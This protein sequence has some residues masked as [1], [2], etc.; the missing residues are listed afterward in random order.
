MAKSPERS[1]QACEVAVLCLDHMVLDTSLQRY[2]MV[3]EV[4]GIIFPLLVILPQTWR[5]NVKALEIVKQLQ[6]PYYFNIVSCDSDFA[7]R[8]RIEDAQ[9]VD[10][11]IRT[12]LSLAESLVANPNGHIE[13]LIACCK[14][15]KIAKCLL[16]F[17]ILRAF[18]I[19]KDE[20]A[21]LW[22]LYDVCSAI[23]KCEW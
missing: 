17:I 19:C 20:I 10:I 11:N 18:I 5:V 4:A 23:L 9:I 14:H 16:F 3:K 2:Y 7:K 15:N 13:W 21:S 6:W 12:I 1:S 22:R 8:Q